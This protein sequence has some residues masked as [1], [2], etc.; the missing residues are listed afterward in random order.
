[1]KRPLGGVALLY[2]LGLLL[3]QVSQ[4][5][6]LL[7]FILSL[8]V[9]LAALSLKKA[10]PVLVWPLIVLTGWANFTW[11]TSIVSPADLRVILSNLP[12]D[13]VLRGRLK[14]TPG[15]RLYAGR[16]G[17]TYRTL[18]EF[19]ATEIRRSGHWQRADGTLMITTSGRLLESCFP[20]DA[21]EVSGIIQPPKTESAPG[22]FDYGVYLRRQGI[23]FEL[24]TTPEEWHLLTR[25]SR[26][27][28]AD[29]FLA[30][31]KETMRLGLP[32]EDQPLRLLWAM[33]L[34]SRNVLPGEAY[35]PFVQSG[36]MHIFAI[37]GLHIALIAGIFVCLCRVLRIPRNWCGVI[38]IPLLWFYTAASGWQPSAVRSTVMMS[39]VIAGWSLKRPSDLLNS[40]AAA[41]LIIL[42]VDPQQLFQTGFQLSFFVVLS[43]ALLLPPL[44]KLRDRWLTSDPMLPP[45]LVPRWERWFGLPLRFLATGLATSIA[46]WLGAWP[47]TAYYF[48]LFSPVTLLANVAMVPLSSAALACNLASLVCGSHL[49]WLAGLFNHSAWFWMSAMMKTGELSVQL[50]GAFFY[51]PSPDLAD[52]AI[53]YVALVAILSGYVFRPPIRKWS[54]AAAITIAAFYGGRWQEARTSTSIVT[55]PFY[56]GTAIYC[57]APGSL[58]DL[59]IDCGNEQSARGIVEPFL[60]AQ[61]CNR[62]PPLA[63]THGDLHVMGGASELLRTMPAEEIISSTARFRS[64]IYKELLTH[65]TERGIRH[66]QVATGATVG[67]WTVLHPPPSFESSQADDAALVLRGEFHNVRILLLSELGRKGQ[68]ALINGKI[69]LHSD[70]VIT[71]MPERSEPLRDALLDLIQPR[72]IIV[73][74]SELPATK[75]AS[76]L[77]KERFASRN[78]PVLYTRESG[79]I[80]LTIRRSTYQIRTAG[81]PPAGV[82]RH[83]E[84]SSEQE[85]LPERMEMTP[86]AD[87]TEDPLPGPAGAIH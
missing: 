77:L 53:Y 23:Y 18:A 86:V 47:I 43:I 62:L 60:R 48:H 56:G 83:A 33:T 11:R 25:P 72:L 44:E 52:L 9:A 46:A 27:P 59:L 68:E 87:E 67:N 66:R 45:E 61:G 70:I 26:P 81:G 20:G 12:E 29:C 15:E 75:R 65:L 8:A 49:P 76:A 34:G 78:I 84:P 32:V 2:G 42:V 4:P 69:D 74:D 71:G 10:R 28:L 5:S 37:S 3:A 54:L 16:N 82:H 35:H 24:R 50:P 13:V 38:I 30:W 22:L 73:A 58:S 7:L 21:V 31:A 85:S 55:V 57:D 40:L 64:G 19:E 39:I 41:A 36:T 6:L 80:S 63:L 14:E 79:T 51:V 17:D 1:M